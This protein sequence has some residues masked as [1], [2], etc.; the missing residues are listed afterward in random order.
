MIMH[1]VCMCVMLCIWE[2]SIYR[3]SI[4]SGIGIING[5]D[6][7]HNMYTGYL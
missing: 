7:I 3:R 5:Y 1:R 2:V 4:W 6:V